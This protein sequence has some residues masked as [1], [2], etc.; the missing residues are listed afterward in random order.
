LPLPC[1]QGR[2]HLSKPSFSRVKFEVIQGLN[3]QILH[4]QNS[5]SLLAAK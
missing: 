2:P 4:L 1:P 3:V 5:V